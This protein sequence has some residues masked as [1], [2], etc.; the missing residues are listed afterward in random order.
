MHAVVF[1]TRK[2]V[3]LML[4]TVVHHRLIWGFHRRGWQSG[5]RYEGSVFVGTIFA[6]EGERAERAGGHPAWESAQGTIA[7]LV[8]HL[9]SGFI[10]GSPSGGKGVVRPFNTRNSFFLREFG[11]KSQTSSD[12]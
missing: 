3:S 12:L 2:I 6:V 1:N 5:G 4:I 8:L 10:T 7:R 9:P 11:Y